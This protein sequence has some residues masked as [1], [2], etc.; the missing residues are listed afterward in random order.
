MASRVAAMRLVDARAGR[1]EQGVVVVVLLAGFVFS[2][3][4][5]IPLATVIA[6]L[7]TALAERSPLARFW[8][9]VVAPRLRAVRPMEPVEAARAQSLLISAALVVATLVLL[10]GSVGLAS[11]VAAVA[12]VV[13]ALGATGIMNAAA[14]IRRRRT[15]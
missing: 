1:F 10:A 4:W 12:A 2:Q 3:P 11:V 14:E 9:R 5:S 7:G 6:L 15:K 13:A 8:Q